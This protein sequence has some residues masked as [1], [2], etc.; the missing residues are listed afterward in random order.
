MFQTATLLGFALRRF[1]LPRHGSGLSAHP[2]RLALARTDPPT[3]VVQILARLP[4]FALR[5][6][7]LSPASRRSGRTRASLGLSI[8]SRGT[9]SPRRPRTRRNLLPRAW[10]RI[11]CKHAPRNRPLGVSIAESLEV[12][13][14]EPLPLLGFLHLVPASRVSVPTRKQPLGED[15]G[16]LVPHLSARMQAVRRRRARGPADVACLRGLGHRPGSRR[17]SRSSAA[18]SGRRPKPVTDRQATDVPCPKRLGHRV[19]GL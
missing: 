1:P 2:A 9:L 14:R 6:S 3:R 17:V 15:D 4:G 8:P 12:L 10:T 13:R 11:A 7:P 16:R 18:V 5:G 19:A